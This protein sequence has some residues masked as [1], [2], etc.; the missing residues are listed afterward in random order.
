MKKEGSYFQGGLYLGLAFGVVFQ[1]G[2]SPQILLAYGYQ[3][4]LGMGVLVTLASA[5]VGALTGLLFD[6][7]FRG[8]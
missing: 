4:A 3:V 5:T 8:G 2:A 7:L 1:V 6:L